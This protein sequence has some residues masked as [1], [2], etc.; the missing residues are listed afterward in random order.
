[1][2]RKRNSETIHVLNFPVN[3]KKCQM[4]DVVEGR[5]WCDH[6]DLEAVRSWIIA[7][8]RTVI[9]SGTA[10]E[11]ISEQS[12]GRNHLLLV[13]LNHMGDIQDEDCLASILVHLTCSFERTCC[14]VDTMEGDLLL[15]ET[16]S[17]LE[18][19]ICVRDEGS[20]VFRGKLHHV[21][22]QIVKDPDCLSCVGAETEFDESVQKAFQIYLEKIK[23]MVMY[24]NKTLLIPRG[25]K[26][27][28]VYDPSLI[29]SVVRSAGFTLRVHDRDLVPHR[30]RFR[31][32]HF[33]YLNSLDVKIP[34]DFG[35]LCPN[36]AIRYIRMSFLLC[37]AWQKLLKNGTLKNEIERSGDIELTSET[38]FESDDESWL[39]TID[40]P[41]GDLGDIGTELAERCAGFLQEQ[42]DFSAV[43]SS[44]PISFDYDVFKDK[45]EHFLDSSSSE[46]EEEDAD[47]LL[48]HIEDDEE[49]LLR[50]AASGAI[51][52]REFVN[53]QLM[54][55]LDAQIT[56]QGPASDMSILFDLKRKG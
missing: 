19:E 20:V 24:H 48:Q 23:T 54:Q 25:L 46:E 3:V 14:R 9:W 26:R 56:P 35:E 34:R 37:S 41:E 7:Q 50:R 36:K 49:K 32:Y 52:E 45:L 11:I 10:P 30:I 1:M 17:H 6:G 2:P 8:F 44:G 21:K 28:L 40:K 33:A 15:I 16:A 27:L 12:K 55:S 5:V 4:N 42:S 53:S 31:R 51:D 47:E 13:S 29:S 18:E 39:E 38:K 43:E 22:E